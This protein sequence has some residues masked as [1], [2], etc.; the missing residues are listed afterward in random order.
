MI[1]EFITFL[2]IMHADTQSYIVSVSMICHTLHLY[3]CMAFCIGLFMLKLFHYMHILYMMCGTNFMYKI[4][5]ILACITKWSHACIHA[6]MS[7]CVPICVYNNTQ[8]HASQP[9]ILNLC[10]THNLPKKRCADKLSRPIIKK[11]AICTHTCT[12]THART[13]ARTQTWKSHQN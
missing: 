9:D 13:R 12:C 5:R 11:M 10:S 8:A 7:I 3:L 6:C 4:P 1:L 2:N